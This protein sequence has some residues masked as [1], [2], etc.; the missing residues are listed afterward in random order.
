M[1]GSVPSLAE[2]F[3]ACEGMGVNVEIKHLP[4]E[5]DFAEV[6]LVCEAVAGHHAAINKPPPR[7]R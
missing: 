4:G 2:A 3:E 5:P 7:S 1:P 6:D